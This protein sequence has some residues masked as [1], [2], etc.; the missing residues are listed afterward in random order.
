MFILLIAVPPSSHRTNSD[1]DG[2]VMIHD[3]CY[4]MYNEED[5]IKRAH[6]F[7]HAIC[8]RR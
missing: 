8:H 2:F 5:G 3:A 6:S 1:A 7:L 4:L